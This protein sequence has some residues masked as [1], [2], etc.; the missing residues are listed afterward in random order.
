MATDLLGQC[1][2]GAGE[3]LLTRAESLN[4]TGLLGGKASAGAHMQMVIQ[5]ISPSSKAF[6]QMGECYGL[7]EQTE[8]RSPNMW[9]QY[10]L[11]QTPDIQQ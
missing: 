6:H 2:L 11:A 1:V 5:L 4:I 7:T 10:M 3:A 9:N 8:L